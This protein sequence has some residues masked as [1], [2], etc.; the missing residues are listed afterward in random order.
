MTNRK[1]VMDEIRRT[2][3]PLANGGYHPAE[4]LSQEP[5]VGRVKRTLDEDVLDD[6][7]KALWEAA[8]PG[9]TVLSKY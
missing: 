2:A 5:T 4:R 6:G 7:I 9:S 3:S 8:P 1:K